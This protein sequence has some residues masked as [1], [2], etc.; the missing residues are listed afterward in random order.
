MERYEEKKERT[1]EFHKRQAANIKQMDQ[2]RA[3]ALAAM[4]QEA[5][6]SS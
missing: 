5:S 2:N 6:S 3:E 1:K 4:A